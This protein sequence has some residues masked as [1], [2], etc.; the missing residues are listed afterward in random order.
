MASLGAGDEFGAGVLR[1]IGRIGHPRTKEATKRLPALSRL[2][3]Q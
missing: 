1:R 2:K 3:D